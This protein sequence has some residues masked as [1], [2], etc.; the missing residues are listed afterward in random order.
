[1]ENEYVS[2][3]E[4]INMINNF[5]K[6]LSYNKYNAQLGLLVENAVDSPNQINIDSYTKQIQEFDEKISAL[7][8]ELL[9]I[10]GQ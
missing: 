7:Q 1:M 8:D 4:K 9:L 2:I 5:I 10:E 6:N 3:E